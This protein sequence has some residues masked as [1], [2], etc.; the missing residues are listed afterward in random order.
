MGVKEKHRFKVPEAEVCGE[1][2]T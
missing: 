2:S 1:Y